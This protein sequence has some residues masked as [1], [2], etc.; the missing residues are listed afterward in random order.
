LAFFE[1]LTPEQRAAIARDGSLPLAALSATQ[2]EQM[3]HAIPGPLSPRAKTMG[4]ETPGYVRFLFVPSLFLFSNGTVFGVAFGQRTSRG[5]VGYSPA[6][7]QPAPRPQAGDPRGAPIE[8]A[9]PQMPMAKFIRAVAAA[10]YVQKEVTVDPRLEKDPRL[11]YVSAAQVPLGPA[12][13]FVGK[14]LRGQ[15]RVQGPSCHV[16]YLGD[17]PSEANAPGSIAL[18]TRALRVLD[19]LSLKPSSRFSTQ[20]MQRLIQMCP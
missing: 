3:K 18:A 17:L 20:E 15:I 9:Q 1:S 19:G 5:N 12:Q 8:I 14:A 2:F 6:D 11:V 16:R 7:A 13:D 4:P 10:S